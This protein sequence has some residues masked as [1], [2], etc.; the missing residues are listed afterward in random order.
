MSVLRLMQVGKA[1][2]QLKEDTPSISSFNASGCTHLHPHL[3]VSYSNSSGRATHQIRHRRE[4][5]R[6]FADLCF[7]RRLRAVLRVT[8]HHQEVVPE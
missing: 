3:P 8:K 6:C 1:A 5:A 7:T 4:D 2:R